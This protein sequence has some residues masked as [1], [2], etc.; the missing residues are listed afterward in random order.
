MEKQMCVLDE[1]KE[2]DNCLECEICDLDPTKIC[3]NCGKC[4]EVKDFASIQID[5][6]YTNPNEYCEGKK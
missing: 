6:I 3:N 4:L 2:C 5:K 1:T